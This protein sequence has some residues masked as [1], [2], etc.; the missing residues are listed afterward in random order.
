[1]SD[2][3]VQD[4]KD[5]LTPLTVELSVPLQQLPRHQLLVQLLLQLL[6]RRLEAV[7]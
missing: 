1:L 4:S 6:P 2:V 7:E 3:E 5:T